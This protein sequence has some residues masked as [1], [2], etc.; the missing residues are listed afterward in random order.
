[1]SL[2]E[3]GTTGFEGTKLDALNTEENNTKITDIADTNESV[4]NADADEL[5]SL[6][7]GKFKGTVLGDATELEKELKETTDNST[8]LAATE[9]T[10]TTETRA[11]KKPTPSKDFPV[12]QEL[13][14][15]YNNIKDYS[16]GDNVTG[17]ITKI[18]DGTI[19][20]DIGYK[21]EGIIDPDELSATKKA[22][23]AEF[24][25]G[26]KITAKITRLENKAGNPVLSKRSADY[27]IAWSTLQNATTSGEEISVEVKRV[28]DGGLQCDYMDFIRCFIPHSQIDKSDNQ[29]LDSFANQTISAKVLKVDRKRKRIVLSLRKSNKGVQ[30][31]A[32]AE[33]L[34]KIKPGQIL[35]GTVTTIKSYG[36]FVNL[37][38]IDG[39]V[40]ISELSWSRIENV[41][42]VLKEG[43]ETEVFVINVDKETGKISLGLK[44]L[45]KD[46]WL[47][48]EKS[49]K[50]GD[51]VKA[52]ITRLMQFGAFAAIDNDIEGLIHITELSDTPVKYP[53]DAV[54]VGQ[55]V[56]ATI[57]RL[58]LE[59][60][61]L[62]LSLKKQNSTEEEL[63]SYST[64]E[65]TT[66]EEPVTETATQ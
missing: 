44:Q 23:G 51:Q 31:K 15:L 54:K 37:G 2:E 30:N 14:A 66:T 25:V 62:A 61:K 57:I 52:K 11:N 8:P 3:L 6:T 21:A 47:D 41:E 7:P 38:E 56:E 50:V 1:M 48:I 19:F 40:H 18:Q 27:E 45:T 32:Q 64:G 39:L 10:P 49:Y 29:N 17:F 35:N 28:L 13:E 9:Q 65:N 20:V 12:D 33:A 16:V 26:D 36:A 63:K 5:G 34:E 43:Q 55:E 59:A 46:P 24:E 53:E 42:D 60:K 22:H 58:D 4:E